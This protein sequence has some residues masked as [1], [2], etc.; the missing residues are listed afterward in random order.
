VGICR[1]E[2]R[3]AITAVVGNLTV[4]GSAWYSFVR[5]LYHHE[6]YNCLSYIFVC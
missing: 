2:Y 1:I 3:I 4:N 5:F 6:Q